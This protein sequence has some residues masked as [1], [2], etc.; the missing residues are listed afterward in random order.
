MSLG[1]FWGEFGGL[2]GGKRA[3]EKYRGTCGTYGTP[4]VEEGSL[5]LV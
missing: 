1:R 4:Q 2:G 3:Q 5:L